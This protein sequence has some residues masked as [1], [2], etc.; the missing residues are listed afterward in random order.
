MTIAQ[1]RNLQTEPLDVPSAI[2]SAIVFVDRVDNPYN[3]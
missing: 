3:G 1:D 2:V